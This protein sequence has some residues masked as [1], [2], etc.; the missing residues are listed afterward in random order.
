MGFILN[1]GDGED[2][3]YI[4]QRAFEE[5]LHD[6]EVSGG[7]G[8]PVKVEIWL[9]GDS[10]PSS[11]MECRVQPRINAK[12]GLCIQD[13]GLMCALQG[14]GMG[15]RAF[16]HCATLSGTEGAE[17][18]RLFFKGSP[19][20]L[21]AE[22]G[23]QQG[24]RRREEIERAAAVGARKGRSSSAPSSSLSSSSAAAVQ[25]PAQ[26]HACGRWL[27]QQG[28]MGVTSASSLAQKAAQD[29]CFKSGGGQICPK[30][31]KVDGVPQSVLRDPADARRLKAGIARA[32]DGALQSW[33]R[34]WR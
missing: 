32:P 2:S 29:P 33:P 11:S 19:G 28:M 3:L 10:S 21:D 7:A 8:V 15:E 24:L 22:S 20:K 23:N 17:T 5:R 25:T 14:V 9:E 26:Q 31:F 34:M 30:R 4:A 18:L 1:G 13:R 16:L 27:T 6:V 12:K